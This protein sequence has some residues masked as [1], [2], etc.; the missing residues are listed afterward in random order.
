MIIS[1]A[2][3]LPVTRIVLRFP[4]HA[5]PKMTS[6]YL[7]SSRPFVQ[8]PRQPLAHATG[9]YHDVPA[10]LVLPNAARF[11]RTVTLGDRMGA[12]TGRPV[13]DRSAMQRLGRG[14]G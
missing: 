12:L 7:A 3:D 4:Q 14:G 10:G 6:G 1:T 9:C 13:E 5:W 8:F 2:T 11:S